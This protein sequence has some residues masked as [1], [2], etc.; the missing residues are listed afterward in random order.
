MEERFEYRT[1]RTDP[2][3]SSRGVIAILLILVIFLGGLVSALSNLNIRLFRA[4]TENP[5]A[6]LSF[7]QGENAQAVEDCLV[8]AGMALQEPDP[9]YQQL[10]DL[11]QGLYVVQVEPGSQADNLGIEAA[12]VLMYL[13]ETPVSSLETAKDLVNAKTV[14][15]LR[16]WRGRNSS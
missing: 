9:V 15:R 6:Q 2:A 11:P 8:L 1:G 10:H 14:H 7:A 5:R 4:L 13:N 12:D 16:L 3:K